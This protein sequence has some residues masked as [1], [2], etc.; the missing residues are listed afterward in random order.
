MPLQQKAMPG[1]EMACPARNSSR[2]VW[3][4]ESQQLQLHPQ[5]QPEAS[6]TRRG[7]KRSCREQSL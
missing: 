3:W 1:V 5:C 4:P 2:W 6:L 7:S